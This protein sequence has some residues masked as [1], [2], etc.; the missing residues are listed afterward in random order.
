[1][2]TKIIELKAKAYDLMRQ[3]NVALVAVRKQQ[4]VLGR[5]EV[6]I[7]NLENAEVRSG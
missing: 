2:T 4:E 1:M 6:E 5:L 7:T 3:I